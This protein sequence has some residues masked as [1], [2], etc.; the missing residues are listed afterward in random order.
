VAHVVARD[1]FRFRVDVELVVDVPDVAANR[2]DADPQ[3]FGRGL[4]AVDARNVTFDRTLPPSSGPSSFSIVEESNGQAYLFN[5]TMVVDGDVGFFSDIPGRIRV[6]NWIIRAISGSVMPGRRYVRGLQHRDGFRP[7]LFGP[8]HGPPRPRF[9][10]RIAGRHWGRGTAT[11]RLLLD[12][13]AI[14]SGTRVD[15]VGPTRRTAA[16]GPRGGHRRL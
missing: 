1:C 6:G 15:H 11:F 13:P 4:E 5:V 14:D 9:E 16:A 8:S 2:V 7:G 3:L 10:A 12:S